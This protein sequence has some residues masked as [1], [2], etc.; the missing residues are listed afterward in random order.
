MFMSLRYLKVNTLAL[1]VKVTEINREFN[2]SCLIRHDISFNLKTR[3]K[4]EPS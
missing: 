4:K 1:K 2:N 3:L